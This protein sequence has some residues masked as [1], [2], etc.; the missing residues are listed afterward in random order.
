MKQYFYQ[1]AP[2]EIFDAFHTGAVRFM[3]KGENQ[4]GT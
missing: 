3:L 4:N 1:I 2:K